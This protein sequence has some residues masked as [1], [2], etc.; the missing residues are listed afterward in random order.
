MFPRRL[1]PACDVPPSR[2]HFSSQENCVLIRGAASSC[3]VKG[4][5]NVCLGERNTYLFEANVLVGSG[6]EEGGDVLALKQPSCS[7]A[8]QRSSQDQPQLRSDTR[9]SRAQRLAERRPRRRHS[10]SS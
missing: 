5:E 6:G 1:F 10:A 2:F 8:S 4:E 7:R 9:A 3:F